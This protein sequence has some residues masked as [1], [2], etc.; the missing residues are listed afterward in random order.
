VVGSFVPPSIATMMERA[1][2]PAEYDPY[3]IG[4]GAP[5]RMGGTPEG[6]G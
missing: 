1:M 2:H 6:A 3:D 5:R 4:E